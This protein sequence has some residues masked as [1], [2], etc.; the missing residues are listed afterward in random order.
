LQRTGNG[1]ARGNPKVLGI[2]LFAYF[3]TTETT[4]AHIQATNTVIETFGLPLR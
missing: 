1:A 4:W 3:F 2:P